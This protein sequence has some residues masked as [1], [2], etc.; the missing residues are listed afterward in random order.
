MDEYFIEILETIVHEFRIPRIVSFLF[1]KPQNPTI[2]G[3]N[4]TKLLYSIGMHKTHQQDLH[5]D[6]SSKT[7]DLKCVL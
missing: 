1:K 4:I 3:I 5:I 2:I 7:Y 6:C